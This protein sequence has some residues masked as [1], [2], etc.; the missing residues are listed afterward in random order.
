MNQDK[1]IAVIMTAY[2]ESEDWIRAS[3]ESVLN[4]TYRNIKLYIM[5]DN[6]DNT[7][8]H[9][10]ICRYALDDERITYIRNEHNMGLVA[11][12]NEL[13]TNVEEDIVARMDADDIC[14]EDRIEKEYAFMLEHNLD[15]VMCGIDFIC[16][17][18]RENG[19]DVPTIMSKQFNECEK[20]G[21]F[22]THPTW[23]LKK[24]IYDKLEGYR[25]IKYCEDYD[26][27]LRAI[28]DGYRCG[29]LADVLLLYRVRESGISVSYAYEQ[30]EKADY[31]RN[32][33][34]KSQKLSDVNPEEL[35][36]QFDNDTDNKAR[37]DKAKLKLDSF[38][39]DLYEKRLLSCLANVISGFLTNAI[40]RRLFV[41]TFHN[42]IKTKAIFKAA[43]N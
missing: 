27:V 24:E 1:T 41:Y 17:D 33:Y 38:A 7:L 32:L 6:P 16:D 11:A 42:N 22:A 39:R 36:N 34:K 37:F 10:I 13:L 3:I 21:N 25:E 19:P 29:R 8:L 31:M 18:K 26:F 35:N 9:E 2:N 23:L 15:F 28:Q 30:F 5:L 14:I 12:L 20:Y 4:H 40:Y 43:R